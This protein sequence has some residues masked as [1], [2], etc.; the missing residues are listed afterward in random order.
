MAKLV[1]KRY[2]RLARGPAAY[3]S[4]RHEPQHNVGPG[5]MPGH[6]GQVGSI[7][8]ILCGCLPSCARDLPLLILG[9]GRAEGLRAWDARLHRE[10]RGQ[11]GLL[12]TRLPRGSFRV[13]FLCKNLA[14]EEE[15]H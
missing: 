13:A 12:L 3:R 2:E 8:V 4:W 7:Q 6:S 5:S 10:K 11:G 14:G 9:E 1:P 15:K